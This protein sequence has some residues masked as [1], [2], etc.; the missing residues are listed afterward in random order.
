MKIKKIITILT[1]SLLLLLSSFAMANEQNLSLEV[2]Y[3]VLD[4]KGDNI[5]SFMHMVS[6]K[7]ISSEEIVSTVD[8]PVIRFPLPDNAQHVTVEVDT[9]TINHEVIDNEVVIIH[10]I[11]ADRSIEL[12]INYFLSSEQALQ[13]TFERQHPVKMLNVFAL[14]TSGIKVTNE[15]FVD[16]GT[17]TVDNQNYNYHVISNIPSN[18][19]ITLNI[20]KGQSAVSLNPQGQGNRLAQGYD[21]FHNPGHIRFWNNSAFARF[22]PHLMTGLFIALL[23]F[24]IGYY[25]YRWA[26]EEKM[27][28]ERNQSN[29]DDVFLRLYKEESV[30]KKKITELQFKYDSGEMDEADFTKRREVYKKKLVAVKLKIKEF[31]E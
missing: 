29:E 6:F 30:L 1:F 16:T 27:A 20:E 7:N 18:D 23:V 17:T 14:A 21:G 19:V 22:D 11:P 31:T 26:R 25:F 9:G 13:Y 2:E 12:V 8:N 5:I 24:S 28:K 15:R 10:Q 3:I 4:Q